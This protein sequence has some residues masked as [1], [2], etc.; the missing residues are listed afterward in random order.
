MAAK[1]GGDFAEDPISHPVAE[2]VVDEAKPI[3]VQAKH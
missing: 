3:N 1:P 2:D